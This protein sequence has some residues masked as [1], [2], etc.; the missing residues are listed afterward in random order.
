LLP[1][2]AYGIARGLGLSE[3]ARQENLPAKPSKAR[4]PLESRSK[5]LAAGDWR[6]AGASR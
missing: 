1:I 6:K 5:P 3:V 4:R 2:I